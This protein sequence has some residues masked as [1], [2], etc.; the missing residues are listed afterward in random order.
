MRFVSA[1][2]LVQL[3]VTVPLAAKAQSWSHFT[4]R[5][6]MTGELQAYATSPRTTSTRPMSFPYRGVEA[7]L[8]FGCD[9]EDEWAYLGFSESPNVTDTETHDG[10]NSFRARVRWDDDVER[11]RMTQEWGSKFIHLRPYSQ[12]IGKMSRAKTVLVELNWYR[13]GE[14]YF[15]FSLNGSAQAIASARKACRGGR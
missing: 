12:A 10:Y 2:V 9:S 1:T 15:R 13:S 4:S 3:L 6:E 5:D 7:W 14:V 11:M 8:A